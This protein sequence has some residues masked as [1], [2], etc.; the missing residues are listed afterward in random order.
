M[1]SLPYPPPRID[2]LCV[3][4]DVQV[5][6]WVGHVPLFEAEPLAKGTVPVYQALVMASNGP[7]EL[8]N[9]VIK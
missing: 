9:L 1:L 4:N 5:R 3:S 2:I 7:V 8:K 6:D